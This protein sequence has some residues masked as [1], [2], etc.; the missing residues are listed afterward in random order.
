MIKP[1]KLKAQE[2]VYIITGHMKTR[3][4]FSVEISSDVIH[5][6]IINVPTLIECRKN[7]GTLIYTYLHIFTSCI[8]NIEGPK[9]PGW[10]YKLHNLREHPKPHLKILKY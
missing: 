3:L 5:N 6:I 9:I 10:W 7:D 4:W 8:M 2:T 1:L